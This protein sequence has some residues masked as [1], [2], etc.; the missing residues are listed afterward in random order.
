MAG[1]VGK[2]T[3][4]VLRHDLK[5]ADIPY[6]IDSGAGLLFAD[7]HSLRHTFI[8]LLD[9]SGATLKETMQLARHSDPKRTMA[10]HGKVRLHDLDQTLRRFPSLEAGIDHDLEILPST[11]LNPREQSGCSGVAQT[12]G[13]EREELIIVDRSEAEEAV[14]PKSLILQGVASDC[15]GLIV[16]D[17]NSAT[18]TR[19][20]NRPINSRM[21]YH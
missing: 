20:K 4:Q 15:E 8:A 3:A 18:W 11:G 14:L 2:K 19:T 7:F 12:V 6:A 1:W 9:R 16:G 13:S 17:E 10:V 21:L 5:A